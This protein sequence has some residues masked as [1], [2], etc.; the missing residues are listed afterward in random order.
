VAIKE[1][2]NHSYVANMKL[3]NTQLQYVMEKAVD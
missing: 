2:S 1:L 3:R